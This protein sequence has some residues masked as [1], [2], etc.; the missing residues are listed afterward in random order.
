MIQCGAREGVCRGGVLRGKNDTV[1]SKN[2][3]CVVI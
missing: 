3:L 1:W 2:R